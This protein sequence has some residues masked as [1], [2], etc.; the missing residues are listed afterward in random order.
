MRWTTTLC[1]LGLV[2]TSACEK[3]GD[4]LGPNAYGNDPT[5]APDA[6]SV[7]GDDDGDTT[8]IPEEMPVDA[9]TPDATIERVDNPVPGFKVN[10]AY[11][12]KND[13]YAAGYHTGEDRAAPVGTKVVA[14]RSGVIRWSDTKGG[15][16]GTWIGL[17]ADNGRNYVYCHLSKRDVEVGDTVVAGDKL[18]EVGATGNVTGPHLHFEDHPK[19][20]FKYGKG[21]KPEW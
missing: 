20:A 17:E 8:P 1:V 5:P 21:R 7:D 9:G 2:G 15:A 12:V 11:G 13:R 10:Y 19:G 14:V 4:T 16:Y 6:G 3:P 18:G